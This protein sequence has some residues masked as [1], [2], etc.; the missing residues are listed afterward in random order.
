MSTQLRQE[1]DKYDFGESQSDGGLTENAGHEIAR[2]LQAL[3][4]LSYT[5]YITVQRVFSCFKTTLENKSENS[6]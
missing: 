1:A 6:I 4:I 2:H 5:Y 3:K